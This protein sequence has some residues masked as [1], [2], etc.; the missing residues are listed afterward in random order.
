MRKF[1]IGTAAI[2]ATLILAACQPAAKEEEAAAPEANVV[3]AEPTEEAAEATADAAAA[4]TDE[5]APADG[6]EAEAAKGIEQN[7]GIKVTPDK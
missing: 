3:A 4:A 2:V 7:G 5:A 6:T 1:T